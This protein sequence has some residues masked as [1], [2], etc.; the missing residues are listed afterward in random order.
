IKVRTPPSDQHE[1]YGKGKHRCQACQS[2]CEHSQTEPGR[3]LMDPIAS[4]GSHGCFSTETYPAAMI[5]A[6][7]SLLLL[8]RFTREL[9]ENSGCLEGRQVLDPRPA[10]PA[11]M[12]FSERER[13]LKLL[14]M[15]GGGKQASRFLIALQKLVLDLILADD[16]VMGDHHH[17]RDQGRLLPRR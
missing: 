9:L 15:V 7:R 17:L 3:W 16:E 13:T 12:D 1:T 5:T 14:H 8:A 2:A 11:G 10:K 4:S 6:D